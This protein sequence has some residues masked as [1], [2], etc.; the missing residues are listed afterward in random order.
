MAKKRKQ[1][2]KGILA[3]LRKIGKL[4]SKQPMHFEPKKISRAYLLQWA[5]ARGFPYKLL[6][7]I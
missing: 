5:E 3:A 1:P 2:P 6:L 7:T 4:G